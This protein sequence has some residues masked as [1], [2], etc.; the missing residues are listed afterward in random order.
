[1]ACY[2]ERWPNLSK[3]KKARRDTLE[4]FFK[5]HRSGRVDLINRRIA[6]INTT[7]A[8]TDDDAVIKPYQRYLLGLIS[9]LKPL[10]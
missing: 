4:T 9:L 10:L 2:I 1:M 5:S 3:L 6:L 8:L 7:I